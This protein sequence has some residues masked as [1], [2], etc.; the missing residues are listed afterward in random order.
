MPKV[1]TEPTITLGLPHCEHDAGPMLFPNIYEVND[2]DFTEDLSDEERKLDF[3]V[4]HFRPVGD[5]LGWTL[6]KISGFEAY[7]VAFAIRQEGGSVAN[8]HI[9]TSITWFC[10]RGAQ[11]VFVSILPPP[12]LFSSLCDGHPL[13][14]LL[15]VTALRDGEASHPKQ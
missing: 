3:P 15:P 5:V 12:S 9:G 2:V 14:I 1:S 10:E 11:F 8:V 6:A 4:W 7:N 13:L